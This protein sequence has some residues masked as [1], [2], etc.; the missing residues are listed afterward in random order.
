MDE[1]PFHELC[2]V[3]S[4]TRAKIKCYLN[5]NGNASA[6]SIDTIHGMVPLH[7]P[8]MNHHAQADTIAALLDVNVTAVFCVDNQGEK[9]LEYAREYNVGGLVEKINGLCNHT[10]HAAW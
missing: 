8:S 10:I 5:K 3:S 2:Y 7:I 9:S 1:A 4:I 6:L